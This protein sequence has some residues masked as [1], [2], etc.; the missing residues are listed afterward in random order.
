MVVDPLCEGE[1]AQLD[2][3]GNGELSWFPPTGLTANDIPNPVASPVSTTTY[4]LTDVT[5]CGTASTEVTVEVVQMVTDPS[6]DTQICL[7]DGAPLS[8]SSPQFSD[9]PSRSSKTH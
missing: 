7:G 4:T 5:L 9:Q 2:G 8:V 6:G 3:G 1:E